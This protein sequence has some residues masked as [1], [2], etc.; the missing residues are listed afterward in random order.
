[1][2]LGQDHTLRST[3]PENSLI[4]NF[5]RYREKP[6]IIAATWQGIAVRAQ[7]GN[8]PKGFCKLWLPRKMLAVVTSC[9]V[10]SILTV[11][12]E[13]AGFPPSRHLLRAV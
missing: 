9:G 6:C 13:R 1:M 2:M 11:D 5:G 3:K 8:V 10:N 4:S 12:S 7:A